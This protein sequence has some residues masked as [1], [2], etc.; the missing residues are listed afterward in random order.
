MK[1]ERRIIR[2]GKREGDYETLREALES[3]RY[4]EKAHILLEEGVFRE[5]IFSEKADLILEGAG[6]DKTTLLWEDGAFHTKEKGRRL[7]TFRSFTCFFGGGKITLKNLSIENR[8]GAGAKA[9][10]A[11]ALYLEAREAF[12]CHVRLSSCQDTLFLSPLPEKEREPGGFYGPR[13]FN[14]R[15]DSKSYFRDCLIEGDVDFIFGGGDAVFFACR[16]RS[17]NRA[18]EGARGYVTAPSTKEQGLGF[19]FFSCSFISEPG[20]P[21]ESVYLARPWR[22]EGRAMFIDCQFGE[23]VKKEFFCGWN[24]REFD[25]NNFRV[26]NRQTRSG[27]RESSENPEGSFSG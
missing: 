6:M 1:D 9:G 2:V 20:L 11:I 14:D 27:D 21:K 12:L 4:D 17:L 18:G 3:V 5:K 19:A 7:G 15:R 10:Q 23:H 13:C 24:K 25:K 16:I 22:E 8:A 26:I